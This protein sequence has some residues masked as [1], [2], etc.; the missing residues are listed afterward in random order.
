MWQSD[1]KK[2]VNISCI[3]NIK[4]L[5]LVKKEKWRGKGRKKLETW[6]R[7]WFSEADHLCHCNTALLVCRFHILVPAGT[8]L[9]VEKKEKKWQEEEKGKKKEKENAFKKL[10]KRALLRRNT[11]R[12]KLRCYDT[13]SRSLLKTTCVENVFVE[14]K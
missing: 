5:I 1:E 10:T 6:C 4:M 13:F 2:N 9:L 14:F 7:V 12:L 11:R 3:K 8:V